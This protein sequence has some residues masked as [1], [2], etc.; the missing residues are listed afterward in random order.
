MV[1]NS[2]S[3]LGVVFYGIVL[4]HGYS[5]Q[6]IVITHAHIHSLLHTTLTHSPSTIRYRITPLLL[7]YSFPRDRLRA[8]QSWAL[9]LPLRTSAPSA[10]TTHTH[11]LTHSDPSPRSLV[12]VV[13]PQYLNLLLYIHPRRS[14]PSA[15]HVLLPFS[16][17]RFLFPPSF[18][19]RR[20][21]ARLPV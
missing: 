1:S 5:H 17:G 12:I 4:L 18:K 11:S 8:T 3:F 6:V 19:R 21:P 15:N 14:S 10:S 9:T 16:P 20:T 2:F 13:A 7:R